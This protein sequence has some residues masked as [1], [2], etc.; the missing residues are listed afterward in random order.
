MNAAAAALA[1]LERNLRAR[2][3]PLSSQA[4][5][6]W[7]R[8]TRREQSLLRG[9]ALVLA[10]ALL[11]AAGLQPALRDIRAA[12]AQLPV[13]QAQASQVDA[14]ILEAQ[15]L[16][17]GRSGAM[18]AEETEQALRASLR[19][20]G[21]DALSQFGRPPEAAQGETLWQLRFANAPAGRVIEWMS[22]LPFVAQVQTRQVDLARS[23]VDGR[24]RPGQLTGVVV[25]ALPAREAP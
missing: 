17:R 19:S 21:L 10:A 14:I 4:R 7:Q 16:N 23:N 24:D 5:A 2:L 13:L 25:L 1:K 11:W 18:S 20:A 15:A 9:G 3:E 8:R 6:A 12:R 22:S